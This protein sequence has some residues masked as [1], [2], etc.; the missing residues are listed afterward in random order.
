ML[1]KLSLLYIKIVPIVLVINILLQIVSNYLF[2]NYNVIKIIEYSSDMII[3]IGIILLSIV[4][5]FCI[6]H[7]IFIY[8]LMLYYISQ[9]IILLT[10]NVYTFIIVTIILCITILFILLITH[11]YLKRKDA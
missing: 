4:F 7:R 11:I 6:Y 9:I 3:L 8:T 5:R 10:N 1:K 2:I